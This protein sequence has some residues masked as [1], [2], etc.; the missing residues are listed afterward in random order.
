MDP[1]TGTFATIAAVVMVLVSLTSGWG[2]PGTDSTVATAETIGDANSMSGAI[3]TPQNVTE[4]SP[5]GP[6]SE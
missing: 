3:S 6:A 2:A 5:A 1:G 4:L